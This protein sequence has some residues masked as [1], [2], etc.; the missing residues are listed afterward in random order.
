ML[1]DS[2]WD[3][4][5]RPTKGAGSAEAMAATQ[6][7]LKSLKEESVWLRSVVDWLLEEDRDDE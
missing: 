7:H 6:E 4:G 2:L 5:L 3:C 1:M